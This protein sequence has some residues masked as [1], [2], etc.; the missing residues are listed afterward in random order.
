[1]K[2][3][4]YDTD[5]I[6]WSLL[7]WD[8]LKEV[9]EVMELGAKKYADDNWKKVDNAYKRYQEA[10]M[11]H[12]ISYVSGEKTDPETGKSHLAHLICS[13][14]FVM[15]HEKGRDDKNSKMANKMLDADFWAKYYIK[16]YKGGIK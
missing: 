8:E 13:A 9:V 5:K 2:G 7:P 15:W 16:L 6:R 12:L 10:S 14:L 3:K 1:M 11:R 4:K